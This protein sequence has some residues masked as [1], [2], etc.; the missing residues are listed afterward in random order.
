M[1]G[2]TNEV[3]AT[4][5]KGNRYKSTSVGEYT[6]SITPASSFATAILSKLGIADGMWCDLVWSFKKCFGRSRG[7]GS[8][9][10]MREDAAAHSLSFQPGQKMAR[11]C[12]ANVK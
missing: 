5:G 3:D 6:D 10:N 8:P 7:A 12:F 2:L 1:R 11:E 9:D 4:L